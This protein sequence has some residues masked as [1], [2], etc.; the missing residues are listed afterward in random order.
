[1]LIWVVDID[2]TVSDSMHRIEMVNEKYNIK[3]GGLWGNDEVEEFTRPEHIKEDG[4][5]AGA[6]I[7]P[8]LAR[9]CGAKILFMTGRS[10]RSRDATRTW[11]KNKLG[12]FYSVPLVM[13][14]DDD[15]RS[16]PECKEDMFLKSVREVYKGSDFVFFEDDEDLLGRLSKYGLALKAPEVWSVIRFMEISDDEQ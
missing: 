15:F 14:P 10:E 6:E 12:I 3:E 5:I 16:T 13:R 11:L 2:G 1:M 9:R 8:E 4:L 7:L